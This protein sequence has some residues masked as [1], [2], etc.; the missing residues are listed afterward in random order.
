MD[1]PLQSIQL[2]FF[3]SEG[4]KNQMRTF[5]RVQ[6]AKNYID[7]QFQETRSLGVTPHVIVTVE[8]SEQSILQFM[9]F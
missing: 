9:S 7:R 4:W 3:V 6:T 5:V 1:F 2:I 8:E